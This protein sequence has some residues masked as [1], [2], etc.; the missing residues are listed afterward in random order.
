M[1]IGAK[2]GE[3]MTDTLVIRPIRVAAQR[4]EGIIVIGRRI[5]IKGRARRSVF[6]R[7]ISDGPGSRTVEIRRRSIRSI[8]R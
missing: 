5:L 7:R 6:A 1:T 8:M 3:A 4:I 2:P